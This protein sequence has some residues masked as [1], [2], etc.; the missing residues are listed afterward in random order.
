MFPVAIRSAIDRICIRTTTTEDLS[1]EGVVR[2]AIGGE[3]DG[4]DGERGSDKH[5]LL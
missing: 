2:I 5:M 1:A 3:K 4:I